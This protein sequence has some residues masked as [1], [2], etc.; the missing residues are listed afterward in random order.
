[1]SKW[2][3]SD[4]P[5]RRKGSLIGKSKRPP[6]LERKSKNF[7]RRRRTGKEKMMLTRLLSP[8]SSKMLSKGSQKFRGKIRN[9]H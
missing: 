3:E 4:T 6:A 2:S 7:M 1:M 9:F 8:L 5:G